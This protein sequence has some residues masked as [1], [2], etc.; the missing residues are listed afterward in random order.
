M[1]ATEVSAHVLLGLP[2]HHRLLLSPKK[3]GDGTAKATGDW[4]GL[5]VTVN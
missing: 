3:V 2:N 1:E 5:R 4:K